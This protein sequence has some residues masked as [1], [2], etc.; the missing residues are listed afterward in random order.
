MCVGG[1]GKLVGLLSAELGHAFVEKLD[2]CVNFLLNFCVGRVVAGNITLR[3][4]GVVGSILCLVE[5]TEVKFFTLVPSLGLDELLRDISPVSHTALH[6][7]LH[8]FKCLV[9]CPLRVNQR[10]RQIIE[11]VVLTLRRVLQSLPRLAPAQAI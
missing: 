5:L 7:T 3:A 1:V 10:P 2:C 9:R 4:D 6:N 11:H 8:Q